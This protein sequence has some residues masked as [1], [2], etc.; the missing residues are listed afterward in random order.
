MSKKLV[1]FKINGKTYLYDKELHEQ[2]QKWEDEK[3]K[4]VLRFDPLADIRHLMKKPND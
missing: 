3:H 4:E 2:Q 1:K